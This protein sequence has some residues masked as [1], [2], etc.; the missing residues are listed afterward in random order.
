MV[1]RMHRLLDVLTW[2]Y[3]GLAEDLDST[4]EQIEGQLE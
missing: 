3:N 1:A 4:I 2:G